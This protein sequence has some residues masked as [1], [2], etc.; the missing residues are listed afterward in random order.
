MRRTK[1]RTIQ[2]RI[3]TSSDTRSISL[4]SITTTG[5]SEPFVFKV[6]YR[7]FC[8]I[9]I[10]DVIVSVFALSAVDHGFHARS[11][12]TKL[13]TIGIC[14][15]SAK[16]AALQRKR[17]DWFALNHENVYERSVMTTQGLPNDYPRTT[18]FDKDEILANH[19]SF[20]TSLNI[21]SGKES[22]DLPYLYWI[23][24]LHKTPC[25]ERYIAG[26]SICSTKEL[27]IHL[28]KILSAVKEGQQ[29][30]CE[31]VYSRSGI[32]H[33]W[34]L[35][36]SKDL[37]DNLKSR[38]FFQVSSIKT[39]DFSTLY[40][41][42]PHDKL[43]TRLKET[44]H[45]AF[46]HRNYGSKCVVLGH[47]STYF[48]NKIQKGKTCYSEEQ[49][50]SM[51]EFLIDNIFVSFGG[52]LFQQVV[53]LPMGTNCAPLLA[54]LFLY[55]YESECL[56][57]LVKDKKIHEARAFNFTYRYIEYVLSINN[58]RFAE[59]LPLMYPPELE[60]KWTTDTASSAS[61]LD[62]YLEFDDSGQLSTKIYDKRDDFNFKIINFPNMCSNIPASPILISWNVIFIWETG[63]WSRAIKRFALFDLLKSLYSDTKILSKYIPSLQKRL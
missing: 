47:N 24:K 39:F 38:S 43:K 34:I 23:H 12:Q 51:L 21:P 4:I 2:A 8:R 7:S 20:M 61:F 29:K 53:G 25:K 5:Q 49:V 33:M 36:N 26:S 1:N 11:V 40:T 35:K 13:Y 10:G 37:L 32:N 55:S 41:T 17:K 9:R 15:F 42:L 45:K 62:L 52:T 46:S 14:C 6:N 60:V 3:N 30:Y 44:I 54:D 63:Y 50:I 57:K 19:R 59:F 48:S 31:T 27:S 28:T 22:E 56:Q 18:S 16:H 58:S